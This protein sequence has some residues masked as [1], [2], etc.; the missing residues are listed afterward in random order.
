MEEKESTEQQKQQMAALMS[1]ADQASEIVKRA[2]EGFDKI[3]KQLLRDLALDEQ[4]AVNF[5]GALDAIFSHGHNAGENSETVFL[6]K[7]QL[8]SLDKVYKASAE[9]DEKN[10]AVSR[11]AVALHE[12]TNREMMENNE[13]SHEIS[14]KSLA[15]MTDQNALL[16]RIATALEKIVEK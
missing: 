14:E 2:R 8:G 3:K 12:K 5:S 4:S 11:E 6:L 9:R 16:R 13:R 10:L 15:A 1:A 7:D